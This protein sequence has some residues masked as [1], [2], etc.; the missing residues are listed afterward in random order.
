MKFSQNLE[1]FPKME[2]KGKNYRHCMVYPWQGSIK[3]YFAGTG[4]SKLSLLFWSTKCVASPK[5]I[6]PLMLPPTTLSLCLL[7]EEFQWIHADLPWLQRGSPTHNNI[8][9]VPTHPF[10]SI[11]EF[12]FPA[13]PSKVFKNVL[14]CLSQVGSVVGVSAH[15]LKGPRFGFL[16]RAYNSIASSIPASLGCVGEATN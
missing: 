15:G 7:L 2:S 3:S 9:C 13:F 1:Y 8:L 4:K 12:P 10:E 6:A 14:C 11:N 5:I 16:S